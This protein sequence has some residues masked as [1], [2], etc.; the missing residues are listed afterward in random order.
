[1]S[2]QRLAA[3]SVQTPAPHRASQGGFVSTGAKPCAW[4]L[5]TGCCHRAA[6][7]GARSCQ[8]GPACGSFPGAP[9]SVHLSCPVWL[10]HTSEFFIS[11]VWRRRSDLSPHPAAFC[12]AGGLCGTLAPVRDTLLLPSLLSR[13]CEACANA[14]CRTM[15]TCYQSPSSKQ[16]GVGWFRRVP[17]L[18]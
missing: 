8:P 11:D 16:G 5:G 15:K 14:R 6:G 13:S 12:P 1:M 18:P 2:G 4:G 7:L 17:S 9:S 10:C 3:D